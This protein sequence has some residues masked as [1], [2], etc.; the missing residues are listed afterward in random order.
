MRPCGIAVRPCCISIAKAASCHWLESPWYR[1]A[2]LRHSTAH[3]R[4]PRHSTAP[5]E[6]ANEFKPMVGTPSSSYWMVAAVVFAIVLDFIS[7]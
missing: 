2:S 1:P 5:R 7:T 4:P 6:P 3:K